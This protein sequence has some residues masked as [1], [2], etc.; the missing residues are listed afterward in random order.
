MLV[1]TEKNFES[2]VLGSDLPVFVDF[3]ANWCGPCKMMGPIVDE[4]EGNFEG[5][6]KFA[7]C[8]ID[9]NMEIAGKYNIMSIPTMMV[10]KG[11]QPVMTQVGA[12]SKADLQAKIEGAL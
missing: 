9:A 4:L 12:A 7:K 11:G 8:D 5:K 10:F 1:I 6:V 3:Y 2:E